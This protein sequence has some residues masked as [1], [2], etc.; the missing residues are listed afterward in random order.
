MSTATDDRYIVGPVLKALKVLDAI[1]QKGHPASLTTIAAELGLPKTSV[2]RYLRTLSAAGFLTYDA[3]SDRY[4]VGIRFRALAT[5]DKSIQ[6]L[7]DCALPALTE[8]NREFNETTNLAVLADNHVVYIDIIESTRAL[9]MQARIGSRDP[10][11]STA[12]GKAILAQLPLDER[13][14]LLSDALPQRTLRT[15]TQLKTIERQLADAAAEGVAIEVGENEEGTMCIGVPILNEIGYPVAAISVSA[16]ER[17][18][19]DEIRPRLIARLRQATTQ[20]SQQL[21]SSHYQ[22]LAGDP[23]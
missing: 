23:D 11:H 8:I 20:I 10:V 17:R 6:R 18:V 3:G 21:A 15:I 4:S 22:R 5:A 2:F 12:L 1:A 13:N 14:K 7:R 9:R 19:T 16:P